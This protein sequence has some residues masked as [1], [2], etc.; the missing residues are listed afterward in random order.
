[1]AEDERR[2]KLSLDAEDL[3]RNLKSLREDLSK[4]GNNIRDNIQNPLKALGSIGS[5]ALSGIGKIGSTA[6]KAIGTAIKG[7]GIGLLVSGLAALW[8][9]LKKNQKIMDMVS[10]AVNAMGIFIKPLIDGIVSLVDKFKANKELMEQTKTVIGDLITVAFTPLKL[11]INTIKL[12]IQAAMLAWEDSMFGGKDADKIKQLNADIQETKQA[13]SDVKDAAIDST[14]SFA[15]NIGGVVTGVAKIVQ[16]TATEVKEA[17][18]NLTIDSITAQA[19]AMT[20]AKKNLDILQKQQEKITKLAETE[21]EKQRQLRD[22]ATKP[23]AERIAA[24]ERLGKILEQQA[25]DEKANLMAQISAQSTL[26]SLDKDNEEGKNALYDLNVKLLDVEARIT[27]QRSE[28]LANVNALKAEE[29]A[30]AQAIIDAENNRSDQEK[31]AAIDREKDFDKQIQMAKDLA[32]EKRDRDLKMFEEQSK[33]MSLTQ[34]ERDMALQ[35]M[36]QAETDYKIKTQELDDKEAEHKA[37]IAEKQAENERVAREKRIADDKAE[38]DARFAAASQSVNSLKELDE[39][40][41]SFKTNM[42]ANQLKNGKISQEEYDKKLADIEIKAAKRKKAYAISETIINTAAAMISAL[43]DVPKFDFGISAG[44]L[45]AGIGVMGAAQVAA[46][47]SQPISGGG[48]GSAGGGSLP[49]GSGANGGGT[50]APSPST[51]FTFD[52]VKPQAQAPQ[53]IKTYVVSKDI[54][55]QQEL[56]RQ[57]IGNGTI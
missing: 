51:S 17:Y 25:K 23:F 48:G 20:Q 21:A 3:K 16:E 2:Y 6:F 30:S 45:A 14:K 33:N 7:A 27:G 46:I 18:S 42:L 19:T 10:N 52:E 26:N 50:S 9:A 56:D 41:T 8:E 29:L 36:L 54:N 22:D 53:V 39:N 47:A 4:I 5:K 15:K 28:Q 31:Q 24:N 35:N 13:L 44:I 32:K 12:G 1:M 37:E 55:T 49:S 43:K 38:R 34:A 40:L 57:T 11:T